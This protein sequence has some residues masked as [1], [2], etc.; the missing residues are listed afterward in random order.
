MYAEE[1]KVKIKEIIGGVTELEPAN[2]QDDDRFRADLHFDDLSLLEIAVDVDLAYRLELPDERYRQIDSVT[3]MVK[4]VLER[5]K[6]L[7]A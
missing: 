3:Q 2:I 4:L 5:R 7:E 6:E 1:V